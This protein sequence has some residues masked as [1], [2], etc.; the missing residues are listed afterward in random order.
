MSE[1]M[2]KGVKHLRGIYV[3][4]KTNLADWNEIL[5]DIETTD[6]YLQVV[7]KSLD[8]S[9]QILKH[10]TDESVMDYLDYSI[11]DS[12]AIAMI[13]KPTAVLKTV[14]STA[15]SVIFSGYMGYVSKMQD[16]YPDNYEVKEWA[17]LTMLMG[18]ELREKH[19]IADK[20][21]QRLGQLNPDLMALYDQAV[22][23]SLATKAG[24]QDSVKA[25]ALLDRVL[26]R[27]KGELLGRIKA[28]VKPTYQSISDQ[29]A[30]NSNL[31]KT[32]VLE[33]QNTYDT[34]NNEL[35][36]VRKSMQLSSGERIIDLLHLIEDHIIVITNSLDPNRIGIIF[37]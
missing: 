26:E 27:F 37:S 2:K 34:L 16:K 19:H 31:T 36:N 32:T 4:G 30:A 15:G 12:S 20:A 9:P 10:T 1:E 8:S 23:A 21:R 3:V 24:I 33:G 14:S 28:S 18:E 6:E 7:E 22:E 13:P 11:Q 17:G 25:A 29:L 5:P 35:M